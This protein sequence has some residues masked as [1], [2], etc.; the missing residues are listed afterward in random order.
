V[1]VSRRL[2]RARTRTT[3]ISARST[4]MPVRCAHYLLPLTY[5]FFP[6]FTSVL[7]LRPKLDAHV[8]IFFRFQNVPNVMAG[9]NRSR[10]RGRQPRKLVENSLPSGIPSSRTVLVVYRL[11]STLRNSR[12]FTQYTERYV[13]AARPTRG[14]PHPLLLLLDV[15]RES[16]GYT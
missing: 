3:Y 12:T 9:R 2:R 1:R 13:V 4:A 5:L 7:F 15:A 14:N 16:S 11:S 8:F 10:V 6:H